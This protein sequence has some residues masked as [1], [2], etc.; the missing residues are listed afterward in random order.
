MC[1]VCLLSPNTRNRPALCLL[2][3]TSFNPSPPP[4]FFHRPLP[5]ALPAGDMMNMQMSA[6]EF[7]PSSNEL[8][9]LSAYNPPVAWLCVVRLS[10]FQIRLISPSLASPYL[11][12]CSG[13]SLSY[14]SDQRCYSACLRIRFDDA[15]VSYVLSSLCL[16][17]CHFKRLCVAKC[18]LQFT[19]WALGSVITRHYTFLLFWDQVVHTWWH[20]SRIWAN[21]PK[22]SILRK[23]KNILR[24]ENEHKF[25]PNYKLVVFFPAKT[26]DEGYTYA[27][28]KV[29]IWWLALI[30]RRS[31][32]VQLLPFPLSDWL[33]DWA[34]SK[35]S[36]NE[37]FYSVL[38]NGINKSCSCSRIRIFQ[39]K[40]SLIVK[41][42]ELKLSR[43]LWNSP[44]TKYLQKNHCLMF[45]KCSTAAAPW[46]VRMLAINIV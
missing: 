25:G 26:F 3:S 27:R 6:R 41:T 30:D 37:V 14:L 46:L 1:S 35:I 2:V 21:Q 32:F 22:M 10:H 20:C 23:K 17:F 7:L 34:A 5:P 12:L 40:S 24:N 28:S 15:R 31:L 11:V 33:I 44:P 29:D 4:H 9:P 38:Q 42:L 18:N 13:H 16:T 39:F 43:P 36:V 8:P 45:L 19:W